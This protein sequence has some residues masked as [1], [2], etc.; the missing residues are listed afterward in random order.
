VSVHEKLELLQETYMDEFEL[1]LILDKLLDVTLGQHRQRL[2]RYQ[3]E[4]REFETRYGLDSPTFYRRFEAGEL[5]DAMDYFE[6]SGLWELYQDLKTRIERL[7][8]F[9]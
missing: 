8:Q 5:G 7:E 3:R 4:L 1:D 9:E 6:W 2:A